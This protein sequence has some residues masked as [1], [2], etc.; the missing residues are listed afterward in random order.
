MTTSAQEHADI[1]NN[2]RYAKLGL[3]REHHACRIRAW[4]VKDSDDVEAGCKK[5]IVKKISFVRHGEGEHN[6]ASCHWKAA[7]NVGEP[8]TVNTDPHFL[9]EDPGL[10]EKGKAQARE[11]QTR[12]SELKAELIVVSPMRRAVQTALISCEKLE[13]QTFVANEDAH[14]IGGA[15]TCDRRRTL[16]ELSFEFPNVDY[17]CISS[18]KDPI[19]S[20]TRES[21]LEVAERGC[22]LMEWLRNRPES[23]LAVFC[24]STFLCG[25]FNAVLDISNE[26]DRSWFETGEMRTMMVEWSD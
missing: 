8:Y 5:K 21:L 17:T 23:T 18:E 4:V 19:W 25:L 16:T 14:E 11:L 12:A 13:H 7:G 22:N 10:T 1:V 24:H 20:P 9:L 26:T 6:A 2:F 15:H 3:A